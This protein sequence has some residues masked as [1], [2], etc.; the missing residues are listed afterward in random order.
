L[1]DDSVTSK[2]SNLLLMDACVLIDYLKTER[3]VLELFAKHIGSLHVVSS[4]AEEVREVERLDELAEIGLIIVEPEL[5]D[6]FAAAVQIG[7]T[8]FQD[9]LCLFTARRYGFT[10]VTNDKNLRK[11]CLQEKVPLIWGLELLVTLHKAGG[12][13][14]SDAEAIAEKIHE[15]NPKHINRKIITRFKTL[16]RQQ[17]KNS[18]P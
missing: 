6:A 11:L 14:V 18:A 9:K 13:P 2:P 17:E 10:C 16:I 15:S 3:S 12:I 7:P 5:E 8:S 1:G 4:V